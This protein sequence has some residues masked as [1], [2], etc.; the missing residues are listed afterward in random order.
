MNSASGG[1]RNKTMGFTRRE[2]LASAAALA[3]AAEAPSQS[4]PQAAPSGKPVIAL[5]S[6]PL[7]FVPAAELGR[8]ANELG[9]PSIDLAVR[10]G[11]HVEP[12]R[13][14]V[15]LP[16]A[17]KAIRAAGVEVSM[18]TTGIVD[19][20]TPHAEDVIA[21]M[22]SLGISRYRFGG[23]RWSGKNSFEQQIEAFRPKVAGLAELNRRYRA[24]ATYPTHSG[25]GLVGASIWDLHEIFRGLDPSL[26]AVNYDIGH[27]TI[28]GGLGG[29]IDSFH[30]TGQRLKGVA[31]KD[32]LWELDARGKWE[33]AWKPLGSG[34]VRLSEFLQLLREAAFAGPVQLHF[35]YPLGGAEQG[36]KSGITMSRNDIFSA[37]RGDLETLRAAMKAA[38]LA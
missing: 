16:A 20:S 7:S 18:L 11:G 8:A 31:V 28:E 38:D 15:D 27:A 6:K 35:E 34:M 32:F 36:M 13:V 9:F 3:G 23:F 19:A 24:T 17:V 30:I 37:I 26:I 10:P 1:Q 29:W 2:I 5:F 14:R 21:T 25:V 33:P 22:T 12:D 4:A